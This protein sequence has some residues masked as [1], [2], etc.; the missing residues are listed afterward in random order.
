[1][2]LDELPKPELKLRKKHLWHLLDLAIIVLLFAVAGRIFMSTRGEAV[3]QRKE[4]ERSAAEAEGVRL[5]QQA[6]SVVAA[7]SVNLQGMLADSVKS[8]VDLMRLRDEFE[9]GL[10]RSQALGAQIFPLSENVLAMKER[11]QEAVTQVVKYETELR[12]REEEIESLREQSDEAL[13]KLERTRAERERTA[14][15]LYEARRAE[16]YDPKGTF[17]ARTGFAVRRDVGE[18]LD[19]TNLELQ[20]VLWNPAGT[21]VGLSL[22]WGLDSREKSSNKEVGLLL[23]RPLVHRRLG[24]DLGAGYS[25]LTES[26]GEDDPG[27]YAA[28][29]LRVS[30]FYTQRLHIGVGA[31]A[32]HGD[33]LPFLGVTIGRR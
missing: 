13:A 25:V 6:D 15:A 9:S 29:G 3:A 27:A 17:P 21:D 32:A 4:V 26:G 10:V 30:P 14:Q 18:D 31:R 33:V 20:H 1:M 22:G 11:T 2:P 28:A 19:L 8:Y 7:A 16:A 5:L 24:L 12:T 23:S